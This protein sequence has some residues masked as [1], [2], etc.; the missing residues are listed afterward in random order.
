MKFVRSSRACV[1]FPDYQKHVLDDVDQMRRRRS[2][3]GP[4]DAA[5]WAAAVP[6]KRTGH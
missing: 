1:C 6:L 3:S 5:Q 2:E 4:P